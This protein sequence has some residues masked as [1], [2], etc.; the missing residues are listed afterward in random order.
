MGNENRKSD[1]MERAYSIIKDCSLDSQHYLSFK[2]DNLFFFGEKVYGMIAY[3]LAGK[4]AMSIGDPVCK[5]E[6]IEHLTGEYIN[7]CEKKGW[8]P[9]FNSVS[10]YMAEILRNLNFSVL[11]YGEEAILDLSCHT[12]AGSGRSTALR[13]NVSKV[14]KSGVTLHEYCPQKKRD[15]ALEKEIADLSEKWY[16]DKKYEMNY[17]IGGLDFDKPYDRRFF[18]TI[19]TDG[20]LL[21]FISFLPYEGG[22]NFC[23]D[24]MHRKIDTMTGVMEHAIISAA[25]KMKDDG[26]S[27]VSLGIAPLAGIDGSKSN[28]NRAEKLMSAIFHGTDFGYNFKNLFRYKKK[29]DPTI[30]EPRYL[31]YHK[32][33]SLVDLAVSIT[34]TKR[35]STDL[36]LYAKCKLFLIAVT[37]GINKAENK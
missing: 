32:K 36:V 20:S 24:L 1:T 25:I 16:A 11:K 3:V 28:A 6:D 7:F 17:S 18:V 19:D 22:K 34:N 2:E 23:I 9:I 15:Y 12:L 33:I 21:T 8:K 5:F 31:V 27:K 35:G 13:R 10:S 14:E 30:W 29:F 26:V 4:K 37:L